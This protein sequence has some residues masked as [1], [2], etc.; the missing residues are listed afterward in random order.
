MKTALARSLRRLGL[1]LALLALG[2]TA[3]AAQAAEPLKLGFSMA[4]TGG[5]AANG[6]AAL[7]A[8]QMWADDVN[9]KGGLLGRKVELVYYD[10]QSNA[11]AVPGIYTKLLDIDKVDLVVSPYGTNLIAPAMPIVMQRGLTMMSL[12]GVGV[13]S[14]FHYD[15]YFQIMPLGP[16]SNAAIP[17]GFFATAMSLEPKPRTVAIVSVD[18]EFGKLTADA[19]RNLAKQAHLEI[20]YD[21]S[22]P[23]GTADFAPV[24]RAIQ[25]T[26][27]DL[28][29]VAAY[30][31]DSV[32]MVRAASELG[33]KTKLFGGGLVGL[34]YASVKTQLGPVLNG[35]VDYELY[36]PSPQLAFPGFAGFLERYQAKAAAAGVDPL[37]YYVPPFIYAAMQIV[38]DAVT[39][40]GSLD[41]KALAQ[42]MHGHAFATIVGEVRFAA[43]GEWEK[44]RVLMT[45]YRG[46]AGK[47]LD[48]FRK[49]GTQVILY[50]AAYKTGDV[51]YPFPPGGK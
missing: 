11:A 36:V 22:Y 50:P 8:I 9:A 49:P 41:Q 47:D 27:P 35:I 39:A 40:T 34:Q 4:L 25:Q 29:F 20:V 3:L 42:Y 38:G 7:L 23:P 24:I 17:A 45:Q 21:R 28:V 18:A 6:K 43:N 37:G 31:A 48:Q 15:R 16:E 30:P 5:I 19:A 26:S 46:V 32:G 51:T 33:L 14:L 13:N 12:F 44:P 2:A 1:A 10:D